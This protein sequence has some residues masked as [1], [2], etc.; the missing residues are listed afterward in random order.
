VQQSFGLD[1]NGL[2]KMM[3]SYLRGGKFMLYN[4]KEPVKPLR[5]KITCRPAT[6]AERDSE[7]AALRIRARRSLAKNDAVPHD[8]MQAAKDNPEN[9]RLCELM[10]EY[11]YWGKNSAQ[12]MKYCLKAIELGTTNPDVYVHYLRGV[13]KNAAY[14]YI[15]PADL[16]ASYRAKIDRALELA[17]DYLDACEMLAKIE[18]HSDVPR[19]EPIAKVAGRIPYMRNW[20]EQTMLSMSVLFWRFEEYEKAEA[21]LNALL[22]IPGVNT[23]VKQ[24]AQNLLRRV[25]Q[26]TGKPPPDFP[27]PPK[28][29]AK[30]KPPAK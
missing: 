8:L 18:A 7:L 13:F 5:E 19:V 25:A 10:A 17:P 6:N 11:A 16:C 21:T 1:F 4:G 12:D 27:Q 29:G 15:L 24:E 26:D 3:Q 20:R 30:S 9:P 14:D 22:K 2:N 28:A 23:T